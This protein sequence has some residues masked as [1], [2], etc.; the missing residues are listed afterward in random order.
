M[1]NV[2][3]TA[4][5]GRCNKPEHQRTAKLELS[6]DALP[7]RLRWP[8]R[9]FGKVL[10][11]ALILGS[12]S[13]PR[14]TE[15]AAD[16]L[17]ISNRYFW[18]PSVGD[19]FVPRGVAYQVWN[20]PVG[21]NQSTNQVNY[22]LVEF[23]KMH[24]NSVRA[25]FTWG[26]VEIAP[27][28][29]D[30]TR[31][32]YLVQRAEALGLKLF[33]I[34]GY[35]YPPS[36]FPPSWRGSNNLGLREDVLN[37]LAKSSPSNALSCL[38]PRTAG[39]LVATNSAGTLSQVLN[40]LVIGAKEGGLSNVLTCLQSTLTQDQLDANLP[41]LLSDVINYENPQAQAAYSNYISTVTARYK[42]SPAIG[43]WILGNEYAYF[44][45]WEDNKAY[46][47]HRF[48][49]YDPLSQQSFRNYLQSHYQTNIATLNA[50]WQ[51]NYTNFD[52]VV[53]PLEYP[54]DRYY[55]GYQD[56]L[57]WR[58]QSIANYVASGALAARLADPNHLRTYSMVGGIFSGLD[59]NYTCEDA[60]TIV[61]TCSAAGAPL[62]FWSINN[63][64]WAFLGSE[65][66]S[67]A[68][69]IGKYQAQSGLPVM[70]SETGHSSTETLFDV[71]ANG[72]S[73][74]GARQPKALPSTMWESLLA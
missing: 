69:G 7:L 28:Q 32:D 29:F 39:F 54:Y 19:Y 74:S 17:Q 73:F 15:A 68:Y 46:S 41:Y 11:F 8:A 31:P 20:P 53:M 24:A 43:A 72:Y 49:G 67:A 27:N 35:Q 65:L 38:P 61:A 58:K 22:D 16:F 56:L 36:W 52:S 71:D 57:Q 26:Q 55:P 3:W 34:I 45:L 10:A 40:C 23:K 63:Y 48:L 4:L 2:H 5:S 70:I 21:A 12:I 9:F 66:R 25:E 44:D 14:V 64:A 18:D 6:A 59:A 1:Q 47:V 30:W 42:D 37:C 13:S 50:N 51:T 33:I 60:K 62:D